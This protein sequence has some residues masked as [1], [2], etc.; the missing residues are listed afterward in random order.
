LDL[1]V[2]NAS[3]GDVSILL[4]NGAGSFS[5]GTVLP[6]GGTPRSIIA[7]NLNGDSD[8]D[9]AVANAGT[10]NVSILLGSS[11][12]GFATPTLHAVGDGPQSVKVG[13]FNG[14]TNL[15]LAVA[16]QFSDDVSVLLG[17]G[18]GSFA[19]AVNYAAGD[20]PSSV[21]VG[22]FN[23]DSDP[24]RLSR[25]SARTTSRSCSAAPA[26]RLPWR[27]TMGWETGRG[28]SLWEISTSTW[29][30]TLRS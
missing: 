1:A 12:A 5:A 20:A 11:G 23:G 8:L 16:N 10:D 26:G 29:T 28:R 15:D 13:N 19:A 2:P 24:D 9:L 17:T 27:P 7:A 22:D 30:R 21:A 4:G 25:T 6:A 18:G 3:S 14:D